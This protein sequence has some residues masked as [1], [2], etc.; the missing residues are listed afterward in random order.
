MALWE[1]LDPPLLALKMG[2]R[3]GHK[4]KN[5]GMWEDTGKYREMDSSLE[6]PE[7]NTVLL[8]F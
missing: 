6:L 1:R 3:E 5:V 4:P 8:T 7:S 2:G